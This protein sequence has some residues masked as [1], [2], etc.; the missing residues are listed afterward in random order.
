MFN[1]FVILLLPN[2]H[3]FVHLIFPDRV[4]NSRLIPFAFHV[5][6]AR[7]KLLCQ[8]SKL[9]DTF[10]ASLYAASPDVP[11]CGMLSRA[12]PIIDEKIASLCVSNKCL[13][14]ATCGESKQETKIRPCY[15]F[16]CSKT[17]FVFQQGET[18]F[19][20]KDNPMMPCYRRC[21]WHKQCTKRIPWALGRLC[22]CFILSGLY[23]LVQE[24]CSKLQ[25]LFGKPLTRLCFLFSPR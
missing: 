15:V 2:C 24:W 9:Y 1:W 10:S 8:R 7:F 19:P 4:L 11:C 3:V 20:S 6:A 13:V 5:H 21:N 14:E 18:Q 17:W 23:L 22:S 12:L 16:T 25:C